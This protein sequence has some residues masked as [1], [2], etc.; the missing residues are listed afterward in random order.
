MATARTRWKAFLSWLGA[1]ALV[2]T[3][4][5]GIFA[6]G[7]RWGDYRSREERIALQTSIASLQSSIDQLKHTNTRLLERDADQRIQLDKSEV[8]IRSRD[9]L[10]READIKLAARVRVDEENRMLLATNDRLLEDNKEMKSQVE[11]LRGRLQDART[12]EL[13]LSHIESLID[14]KWTLRGMIDGN[15]RTLNELSG[16]S[17]TLVGDES[18]QILPTPRNPRYSEL[19]DAEIEQIRE[20]LQK[21][22][23][24]YEEQIQS[25]DQLISEIYGR[26]G[27]HYDPDFRRPGPPA[28]SS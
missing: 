26:I 8:E 6:V 4:V 21:E 25:L 24:G 20:N 28:S 7:V 10:L 16:M 1:V 9:A 18:G 27:I 23:D 19:S 11:T 22:I 5:S 13:L 14:E 12:E 3:V 2:F 15:I 17:Y